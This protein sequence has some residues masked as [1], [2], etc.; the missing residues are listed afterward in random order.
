MKR[1]FAGIGLDNPKTNT[2]VGGKL[3]LAMNYDAKFVAISGRRYSRQAADTMKSYRHIPVFHH[4]DSLHDII[5]YDC[6]PIAVDLV[7]NAISLP[8]F[9]HPERA[10]YIFGAEDATLGKRILDWCNARVYIPT[11]R[12]MNLAITVGIVL[13]DRMVKRELRRKN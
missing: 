12:C 2:N 4:L 10:F 11:D 8:D 5:P 9:T 3:R 6:V 7:E 1:G 13:Y